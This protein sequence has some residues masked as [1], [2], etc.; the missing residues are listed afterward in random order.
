MN[1]SVQLE[2]L[3]SVMLP[4]AIVACIIGCIKAYGMY[5]NREAV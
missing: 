1:W 3:G 2:T 4:L 5:V